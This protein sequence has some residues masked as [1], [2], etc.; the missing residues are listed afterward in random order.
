[1]LSMRSTGVMSPTPERWS[2]AGLPRTAIDSD[3]DQSSFLS[4]SYNSSSSGL[5]CNPLSSNNYS[6]SLGTFGSDSFNTTQLLNVV[7][8]LAAEQQ[9]QNMT[10]TSGLRSPNISPTSS[11]SVHVSILTYKYI[12]AIYNRDNHLSK[13]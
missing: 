1:M 7:C 11:E 9:N 8:M 6:S 5:N 2:S 3:S 4:S 12:S 10:M 13:L